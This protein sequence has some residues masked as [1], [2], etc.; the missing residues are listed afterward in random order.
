MVEAACPGPPRLG[1]AN[2]H[3]SYRRERAVSPKRTQP[4]VA[5]RRAGSE[6]SAGAPRRSWSLRRARPRIA[7]RSLRRPSSRPPA[8]DVSAP[9][10][11]SATTDR[12]STRPIV[13]LR[14]PVWRN[15]RLVTGGFGGCC[16]RQSN[17]AR[18]RGTIRPN[19]R[20][21]HKHSLGRPSYQQSGHKRSP[22]PGVQAHRASSARYAHCR[23]RGPSLH[24][25][26]QA[27]SEWF[28]EACLRSEPFGLVPVSTVRAR[29]V[30]LLWAREL[31]F[32]LRLTDEAR[33]RSVA[34]AGSF[35]LPSAAATVE[36]D[37]G[38]AVPA[39]SLKR[40]PGRSSQPNEARRVILPGAA[41]RR[42][43]ACRPPGPGL[44]M[45]AR[46]DHGYIGGPASGRVA[47]PAEGSRPVQ[48]RAR[49]R[50]EGAQ[51]VV[52]RADEARPLAASGPPK[53]G[54]PCGGQRLS[55][56]RAERR[57]PGYGSP[58]QMRLG[59]RAA[60]WVP[61]AARRVRASCHRGPSGARVPCHEKLSFRRNRRPGS[62]RCSR[63]ELSTANHAL[64]AHLTARRR[65]YRRR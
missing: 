37:R 42:R 24:S 11:N 38:L 28:D 40:P 41:G 4:A 52:E 54:V 46:A 2:P 29:L 9:P 34:Q 21:A 10:S 61:E 1:K 50:V 3:S 58:S 15:W 60:G 56:S 35:A 39:C 14:D 7:S 48:K 20:H 43:P 64:G 47:M 23:H 44:A 36:R 6:E 59:P 19:S 5:G 31:L 17:L 18:G 45:A 12:P 30:L 27:F 49:L 65:I 16:P 13:F 33:E 25:S 55:F 32:Q 57:P 22:R 26:E 63:F 62:I 51:I 53:L 8:S